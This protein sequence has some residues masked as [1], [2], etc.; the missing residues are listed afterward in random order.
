MSMQGIEYLLSKELLKE[1]P[2]DIAR[3]LSEGEGLNKTAIGEYLGEGCVHC[4][5]HSN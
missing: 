3:F 1:T 2:E 4:I 5:I